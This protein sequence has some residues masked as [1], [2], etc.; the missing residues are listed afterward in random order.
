MQHSTQLFTSLSSLY[1]KPQYSRNWLL[2][3][4]HTTHNVPRF[5]PFEQSFSHPFSLH[6]LQFLKLKRFSRLQVSSDL[7]LLPSL[8]APMTLGLMTIKARG[9][10]GQGD[11]LA[12]AG[13]WPEDKNVMNRPWRSTNEKGSWR[14]VINS[15]HHYIPQ[16]F[17]CL[18]KIFAEWGPDS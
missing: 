17:F 12:G 7:I 2:H 3:L 5:I 14:R 15:T 18:P 4:V 6:P 1:S 8:V 13:G 10:L 16:G 11:V 9:I